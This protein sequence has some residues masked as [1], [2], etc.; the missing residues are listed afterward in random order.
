MIPRTTTTTPWWWVLA[1]AW[2]APAPVPT[3]SPSLSAAAFKLILLLGPLDPNP[4]NGSSLWL[5]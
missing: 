1:V 4:S 5:L 2:F 3:T